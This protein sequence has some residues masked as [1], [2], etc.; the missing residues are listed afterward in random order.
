M[1]SKKIV[2]YLAVMTCIFAL[3][4][5]NARNV[6][7]QTRGPGVESCG[8]WAKVHRSHQD[9]ARFTQEAWVLGYFSAFSVWS[10]YPKI[11]QSVDN[12]GIIEAI[13]KYCTNN[14]LNDIESAADD[15]I[16]DALIKSIK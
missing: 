8:S 7:A 16:G 14:P 2:R 3:I 6:Q 4:L 10:K 13:T 9:F 15:I 5:C 11:L 12:S 1:L